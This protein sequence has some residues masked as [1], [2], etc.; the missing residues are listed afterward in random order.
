MRNKILLF[1]LLLSL[2]QA[3]L[4]API[5]Q[6]TTGNETN[7][8]TL[9]N[10]GVA[11]EQAGKPAEALWFYRMAAVDLK[12]ANLAVQRL[13]TKLDLAHSTPPLVTK[14]QAFGLSLLL[15]LSA[16]GFFSLHKKQPL[17]NFKKWG[18]ASL[19]LGLYFAFDLAPFSI[20]L[21]MQVMQKSEA[22]SGP[23]SSFAAV[24]DFK[25]GEVITVG[26]KLKGWVKVDS[27]SIDLGAKELWLAQS[28]L[29]KLAN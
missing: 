9:Y 15:F 25:A 5:G 11:K 21:Q 10:Q 19:A 13:E 18:L 3:G 2:S 22:F 27:A 6:A 16:I 28:N 29:K 12:E 14:T 17:K 20:N 1:L 23:G 8:I 26:R 24:Q 4:A 7:P